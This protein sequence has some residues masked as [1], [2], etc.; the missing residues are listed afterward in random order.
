MTYYRTIRGIRYD[1][2]LLEIAEKL[3]Q[4]RD[5]ARLSQ[6]DAEVLLEQAQDGHTLTDVERETLR[7]II[8][9]FSF[10]ESAAQWLSE[11]SDAL[12]IADTAA[13]VDRVVRKEFGLSGLAIDIDPAEADRQSAL[14]GQVSL[15]IALRFA[16]IS[17]FED[18][19]APDTPRGTVAGRHRLS[20][21]GF[22]DGASYEKAV[23]EKLQAYLNDRGKL[24]LLPHTNLTPAAYSPPKYGE[25]VEQN[26]IFGLELPALAGHTFWAIVQ[27]DGRRPAYNYGF[28]RNC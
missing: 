16:L 25:Q 6:A 11:Q 3:A 4:A 2:S 1:R 27:R 24:Y 23:A 13:V 17:W 20:S 19:T 15:E 8:Q 22:A 9:G 18:E 14:E 12:P 5:D 21:A 7:Y 28:K 10:T 26:W